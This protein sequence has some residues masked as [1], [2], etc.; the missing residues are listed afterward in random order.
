MEKGA[1]FVKIYCM[2]DIH[3]CLGAL[4]DAL[5]VVL[6]KLD[7]PDTV[8]LFMGDYIHGGEDNRGVLKKIMGLVDEYGSERVVVLMGNHESWVLE[9]KSTIDYMNYYDDPK[10]NEGEVFEGDDIYIDFIESMHKYYTEGNTIFVHAG[11]SEEFGETW[12]WD[13]TDFDYLEKYP[14]ETGKIEGLEMKVVAGHVYTSEIANNPR[15]NGIFYD[16]ESHYYIDGNVLRNGEIL[17]LMVDTD[18]DKYYQIFEDGYAEEIL[19]YSC[20]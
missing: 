6:D 7:E 13:S 20:L 16:G 8:L 5:S 9:E 18:E 10:V 3:G 19:P 4:E 14:A 17:V 15:F 12:E 1:I 11:I 2:S